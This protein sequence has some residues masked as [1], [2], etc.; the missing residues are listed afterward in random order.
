MG[1]GQRD[2]FLS[3]IFCIQAA[4]GGVLIKDTCRAAS[5]SVGPP[6]PLEGPLPSLSHFV[7]S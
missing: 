4:G 3:A 7:P 1:S 5:V 2:K 6:A